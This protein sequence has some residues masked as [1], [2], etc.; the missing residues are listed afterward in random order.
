MTTAADIISS[1]AEILSDPDQVWV[2]DTYALKWVNLAYQ[3]LQQQLRDKAVS[4]IMKETTLALAANVTS[5]TTSS[6]PALPTDFIAPYKLYEK[7]T[8]AGSYVPMKSAPFGFLNQTAGATGE[9]QV[10]QW[11]NGSIYLIGCT[12]A[13]TIKMIYFAKFTLFTMPGDTV[14]FPDYVLPLSYLAA[15]IGA[16]SRGQGDL[17]KDLEAKGQ[18]S[19]QNIIN[20]ELKAA[21]AKAGE[22]GE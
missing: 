13:V 11:R 22:F 10:Y 3:E 17:A 15:A 7:L 4:H 14:S 20:Y 5:I 9:Q 16:R 12:A 1:T 6:T 19:I 8:S 21:R 18:S 2:T